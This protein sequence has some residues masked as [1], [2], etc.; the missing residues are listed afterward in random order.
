MKKTL[1]TAFLALLGAALPATAQVQANL[2]DLVLGFRATGGQ[3]QTLN[4]E[5]DLG[6]VS[7]YTHP[8][9][10]PVTITRLVA[11]DLSGTYG[12]A[13]NARTDLYWGIVGTAGRVGTGGPDGQPL[14]TLWATKAESTVGTKSD[15][16]VPASRSAQNF[17]SSGI[18]T[19]LSSAP[20]SLNGAMATPNSGFAAGITATLPGSYSYQDT[21]QPGVSFAFFSPSVENTVSSTWAVSD[22]WELQPGAAAATYVGSFGL[23]GDGTLVF[24]TSPDYFSGSATAPVVTTAPTS[25][26]AAAG[27]AVSLSV[28]ATGA[29]SYAWQHDGDAVTGGT[30]STLNL[31]NVSSADAGLY[32]VKID[33]TGGT[34]TP[35]PAIVGVTTT[36]EI[37]GSGEIAAGGMNIAHPNGNHYDQTVLTGTSPAAASFTTQ[38]GRVTR[39]SYID[40]NDDIVQVEFSGAG[41][42]SIVLDGA[43]GPANPVNYN[44]NFQYVKGH[45]GI[46]VTGADET[47]NLLVFTVGRLTAFDPTGGFNFLQPV[48]ATNNPANNGSS[49]FTGHATTNYD[50]V[51]DLAFVAISSTDG[52]FGGLRL[53]NASL[54]ATKGVVGIYAPGVAFQGPVYVGNIDAMGSATPYLVIG[55]SAVRVGITGGDLKQ[56]NGGAVHVAGFTQLHFQAGVT[57][58]NVALPSQADKGQLVDATGADVTATVALPPE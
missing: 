4:L 13:W 48:S 18:E 44:Q 50:G 39:L 41:T 57:S 27:A 11:A 47:S 54:W 26:S 7:L 31:T 28:T 58:N 51:A 35:A 15:P 12:S 20:G 23:K 29:S 53:S 25:Q 46:V 2:N 43:S 3:G 33:G 42:V 37:I 1:L 55:S 30:S 24:A 34:T 19:L 5:V 36:S 49:L 6:N 40:M 9:N 10:A 38:G 32:T 8:A 21:I 52:K 16:F 14:A 56:D 22:L 45:A 17:A